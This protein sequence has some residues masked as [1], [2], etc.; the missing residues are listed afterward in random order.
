MAGKQNIEM[1]LEIADMLRS[2]LD[3]RVT[4]TGIISWVRQGLAPID[5][6]EICH[7]AE[8]E[9]IIVMF[10]MASGEQVHIAIRAGYPGRCL[11]CGGATSEGTCVEGCGR[12]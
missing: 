1:A 7:G 5:D 9:D 10:A 8:N 3:R 11:T 6:A 12:R 4:G 2:I